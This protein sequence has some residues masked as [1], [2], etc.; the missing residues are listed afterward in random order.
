M[1]EV[2]DPMQLN[3]GHKFKSLT[4]QLFANCCL[5]SEE[6]VLFILQKETQ[7]VCSV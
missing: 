3:K 5:L 2:R 7:Q 1:K 6:K 4:K